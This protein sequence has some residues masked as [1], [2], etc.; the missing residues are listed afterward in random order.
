MHIPPYDTVTHMRRLGVDILKRNANT[1]DNRSTQDEG[2]IIA[3]QGLQGY[4]DNKTNIGNTDTNLAS[5]P[6]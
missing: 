3:R 4:K 5:N 2:K 6:N 1:V